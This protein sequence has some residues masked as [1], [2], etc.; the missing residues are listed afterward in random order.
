MYSLNLTRGNLKLTKLKTKKNLWIRFFCKMDVLRKWE[1][2]ALFCYV[3]NKKSFILFSLKLKISFLLAWLLFL[4]FRG[5]NLSVVNYQNRGKHTHK[6][7]VLCVTDMTLQT[8]HY[9]HYDCMTFIMVIL[10]GEINAT[11]IPILFK[12]ITSKFSVLLTKH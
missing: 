1:L 5:L 7:N 2:V 8:L 9:G 4:L 12:F 3:H 11:C 10:L 6:K